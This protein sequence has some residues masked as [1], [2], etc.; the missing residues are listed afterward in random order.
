MATRFYL[1]LAAFTSDITPNISGNWTNSGSSTVRQ[2]KPNYTAGGAQTSMTVA[3][4][5]SSSTASTLFVRF[6]SEALAA[7]TISGNIRGQLRALVASTTGCTAITKVVA[8]IVNSSGTIRATLFNGSSGS[9][10]IPTSLTNRFIPASTALTSFACNTGDRLVFE[11]G[12]VRTA[13]TTA[14]N[15]SLSF[16]YTSATD[17]PVD[18]TTTATNNPWIEISNTVTFSGVLSGSISGTST[19][20]AT[21]GGRTQLTGSFAGTSSVAASIRAKGILIA[22]LSGTSSV[23]GSMQ[24][25]G[26]LI[27][28]LLGTSSLSA[29]V[30]GKG[31]LSGSNAGIS[32]ISALLT[33]G[34]SLAGPINGSSLLD[35]ILHGTG[36]LT[37]LIDGTSDLSGEITGESGIDVDRMDLEFDSVAQLTLTAHGSTQNASFN[38]GGQQS[39]WADGSKREFEF[40]SPITLSI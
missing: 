1:P 35:A 31:L 2:T 16:G 19:V 18:E 5:N 21:L 30:Q 9:S 40:D 3:V 25:K 10:T 39:I 28:S 27:A 37:G 8:T 11:V 33:G 29:T 12:L 32:S 23:S 26:T 24:A 20:S 38:S 17:L 7:Q 22:S 6:V 13:G 34:G 4:D 15:G 14:R 36:E